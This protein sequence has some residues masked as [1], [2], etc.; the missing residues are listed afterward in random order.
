MVNKKQR[1]Q[2][3]DGHQQSPID[4]VTSAVIH[5]PTLKSSKLKI[6]YDIGDADT[7]EVTP[8]GFNVWMKNGAKS[9]IAGTHLPYGNDYR[10]AQFHAHWGENKRC[11]SEH[12]LNG[13]P[14][15]GEIHCV[16][17]NTSYGTSENAFKHADGMTVLAIFLHEHGNENLAFE[18]LID[19]IRFA[20]RS[21]DKKAKVNPNFDL[22]LLMP[23]KHFFYTYHGSLTT[24]PH[25]EC[26]IWTILR[27][28]VHIGHAQME[29]LRSIIKS[30]VR[31]IQP[32]EG[33]KI[34]ASFTLKPKEEGENDENKKRNGH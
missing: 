4:I 26:V 3:L 33:R 22:N 10:L 28:H 31:N 30:N 6:S 34:R 1:E 23:E 7:V 18:P 8:R 14:Y 12:F 27:R 24:P 19:A 2:D 25:D 15:S 9:T 32:L 13:K 21:S 17:W 5:D 20:Q 29:V 11:G 16:F